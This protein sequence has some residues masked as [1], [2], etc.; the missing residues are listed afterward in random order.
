MVFKPFSDSEER[1]L[2]SET[3]DTSNFAETPC[4]YV[5]SLKG[6]SALAPFCLYLTFIPVFTASFNKSKVLFLPKLLSF[7]L[8]GKN[9]GGSSALGAFNVNFTVCLRAHRGAD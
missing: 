6:P 7:S 4:M 2:F 3:E 5:Y 8:A 9:P 1:T